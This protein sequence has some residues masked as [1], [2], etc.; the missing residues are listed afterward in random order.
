MWES[1]EQEKPDHQLKVSTV[2][3][4]VDSC[5]MMS[6]WQGLE[7]EEESEGVQEYEGAGAEV[8]KP[9]EKLELKLESLGKLR[10][11]LKNYENL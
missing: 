5:W 8:K 4:L 10:L 6:L 11:K 9:R 2:T 3:L 1:C 7:D